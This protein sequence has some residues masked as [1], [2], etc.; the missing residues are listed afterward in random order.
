MH[1]LLAYMHMGALEEKRKGAED[2]TNV[3]PT[4]PLSFLLINLLVL[5]KSE[6]LLQLDSRGDGRRQNK[7]TDTWKLHVRS[8]K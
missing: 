3:R 6:V 8:L 4:D 1:S 2:A 7:R 5:A